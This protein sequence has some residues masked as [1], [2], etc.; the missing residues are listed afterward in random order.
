MQNC[1]A[2]NNSKNSFVQAPYGHVIRPIRKKIVFIDSIH[3]KTVA[4]CEHDMLSS[5]YAIVM[6]SVTSVRLKF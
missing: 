4:T 6:N 3:G 5:P 1:E 2:Q